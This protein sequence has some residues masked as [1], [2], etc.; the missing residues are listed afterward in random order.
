MSTDILDPH[1]GRALI[2]EHPNGLHLEVPARKRPFQLIF[3]CAW[4]CMWAFGWLSAFNGLFAGGGLFIFIWLIGWTVGGLWAMITVG[5][6]AIGQEVITFETQGINISRKLGP[7]S[8]NWNCGAAHIS[9]LRA[10]EQPTSSFYN[11]QTAPGFLSGPAHGTLKFDYGH[12]T[13][14]FGQELEIGEAK[15]ILKHIN[16]RFPTLSSKS[17]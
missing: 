14:G 12:R 6:M 11:N 15:Q 8:R 1:S 9:D 3:L 7:F 5:W 4:L 17:N 10:T 2:N 16:S 13:L